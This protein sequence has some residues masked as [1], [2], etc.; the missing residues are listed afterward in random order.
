MLVG[1]VYIIEAPPLE[2][3]IASR[4][5]DVTSLFTS[6]PI[7]LIL[8]VKNMYEA[9]LMATSIGCRAS[10]GSSSIK[11]L[12]FGYVLAMSGFNVI[13]IRADSSIKET[14]EPLIAMEEAI[15]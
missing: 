6:C 5:F 11:E 1:N 9:S 7:F 3:L 2:A 12:T 4:N 10:N 13:A 8:G 14:F 15:R